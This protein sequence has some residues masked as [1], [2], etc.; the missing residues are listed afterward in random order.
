MS[1]PSQV[2]SHV[3]HSSENCNLEWSRSVE[4]PFERREAVITE[5]EE[6]EDDDDDKVQIPLADRAD[7]NLRQTSRRHAPKRKRKVQSEASL[8]LDMPKKRRFDIAIKKHPPFPIVVKA[9]LR[10]H[11]LLRRVRQREQE[12]LH[13][14]RK[15][16]MNSKVRHPRGRNANLNVGG[17]FLSSYSLGR[18]RAV[19]DDSAST[20]PAVDQNAQDASDNKIIAKILKTESGGE[21]QIPELD[22]LDQGEKA[23][24]AIDYENLSDEDLFEKECVRE[25]SGSNPSE[26]IGRRLVTPGTFS[27]GYK[28][29]EISLD[30]S[31]RE[32]NRLRIMEK[33]FIKLESSDPVKE[34][35][36]SRDRR[37]Q[38]LAYGCI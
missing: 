23:D 8:T 13:A 38:N 37:T 30:L 6:E 9:L 27:P 2:L 18:E 3:N 19:D 26:D 36:L 10:F 29:Y 25:N 22:P 20:Q 11:R 31:A 12:E 4:E 14:F 17:H 24:D 21:I 1:E 33:E 35:K 15:V 28:Y 5:D 34:T 32:Q 7:R 16:I